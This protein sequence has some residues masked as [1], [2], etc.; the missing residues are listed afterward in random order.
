MNELSIPVI[1][2][3]MFIDFTNVNNFNIAGSTFDVIENEAFSNFSNITTFRLY[4]LAVGTMG[5]RFLVLKDAAHVFISYC[6]FKSWK[7]CA[8]CGISGAKVVRLG[9]NV[10]ESSEGDVFSG[11]SGVE[12]LYMPS[13]TI[14]LIVARFFPLDLKTLTFADNKVTTIVCQPPDM[15]YPS[16]VSYGF[17]VNEISCDCR[18]NWMWMNWSQTKA[19][20]V[21]TGGFSC[22][23]DDAENTTSLSDF[24]AMSVAGNA[25]SC[26]GLEAVNGCVETSTMMSTTAGSSICSTTAGPNDKSSAVKSQAS[27]MC[28]IAVVMF[29]VSTA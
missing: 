20:L 23:K 26:D 12:T 18:L 11:M 14:P 21:L 5:N 16:T 15:D 2:S 17:Y 1:R 19:A 9:E 7:N 4:K 22:A 3:A 28:S 27:W 25:P 6:A 29:I 10:I 13:N 24:F 8:F